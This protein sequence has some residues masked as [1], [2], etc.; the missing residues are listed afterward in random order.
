MARSPEEQRTLDLAIIKSMLWM[1]LLLLAVIAVALVLIAT[2]NA[3]V[4]V[5][6]SA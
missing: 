6:P 2:G 4:T 1:V 3:A 5:E